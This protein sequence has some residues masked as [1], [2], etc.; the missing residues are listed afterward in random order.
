MTLF[1]AIKALE[2]YSISKGECQSTVSIH[3]YCNLRT[4]A[5]LL[6]LCF[7]STTQTKNKVE[8]FSHNFMRVRQFNNL[9]KSFVSNHLSLHEHTITHGTSRTH[10]CSPPYPT[11]FRYLYNKSLQ[12]P[13][14][15]I[16]NSLI[17][18]IVESCFTTSACNTL[19]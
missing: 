16:N 10:S 1:F 18:V 4:C 13:P 5:S 2:E 14:P 9:L 12:N 8:R 17:A 15:A 7:L 3:S 11:C 6:I 19:F